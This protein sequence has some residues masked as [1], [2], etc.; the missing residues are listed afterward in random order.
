MVMRLASQMHT[1]ERRESFHGSLMKGKGSCAHGVSE[2]ASNCSRVK[3]WY[4]EKMQTLQESFGKARVQSSLGYVALQGHWGDPGE[5]EEWWDH[6]L[7]QH[8]SQA[9]VLDLEI[10]LWQLSDMEKSWRDVPNLHLH[11]DKGPKGRRGLFPLS[12]WPLM[13]HCFH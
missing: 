12:F 4:G 1:S 8:C 7:A 13:N 3:I 2:M 9:F 11:P 6:C 10:L 5:A